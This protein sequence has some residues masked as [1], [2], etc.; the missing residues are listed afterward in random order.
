VVFRFV[1][2]INNSSSDSMTGWEGMWARGLAPGAAFDASR[3]E[4]A[5]Q[6]LIDQGVLPT[7]AALVPGC[8]R[9][10]AVAALAADSSRQVLGLEI[11]PTAVKEAEKFLRKSPGRVEVGDFFT[12]SMQHTGRYNLGYDCTFLCAIPSQMRTEWAEEWSKLLQPG[13]ELVTLIFPLRPQGPDPADGS[14]GGGPPFALS[15][16]LVTQLLEP[17]GFELISA[18]HVPQE[19]LARGH[20]SGEIIARWRKL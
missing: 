7:G 5:L 1:H 19:E 11:A 2:T 6:S 16:R 3:C 14:I 9:G 13:G 15:Q 4:P 20:M 18:E 17:Q 12:H 10:Y 8:G